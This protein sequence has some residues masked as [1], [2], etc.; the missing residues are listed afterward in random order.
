M[1]LF[2]KQAM[3]WDLLQEI[4]AARPNLPVMILTAYDTY[5]SDPRLASADVYL[6]KNI[7]A[8]KEMKDHV[9]RYTRP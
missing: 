1:D 3:G 5:K 2:L 6:L 8:P 9:A 7:A 4:K